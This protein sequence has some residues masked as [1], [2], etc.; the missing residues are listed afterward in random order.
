MY[1]KNVYCVIVVE[2]HK[3]F[4]C[5]LVKRSRKFANVSPLLLYCRVFY[6]QTIKHNASSEEIFISPNIVNHKG[7]PPTK[8]SKNQ[9]YDKLL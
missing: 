2:R 3:I 9:T 8:R 1:S 6:N 5:V 4:P 7:V